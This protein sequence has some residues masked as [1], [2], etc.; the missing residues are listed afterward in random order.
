MNRATYKLSKQEVKMWIESEGIK[1]KWYKMKDRQVKAVKAGVV[2]RLRG[3]R[4]INQ[5]INLDS[6]LSRLK[7]NTLKMWDRLKT[8]YAQTHQAKINTGSDSTGNS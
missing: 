7:Q 4:V 5:S 8:S 2:A 6:D 1:Q 3:V